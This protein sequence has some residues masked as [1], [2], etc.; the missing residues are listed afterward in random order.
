MI[1][2]LRQNGNQRMNLCDFGLAPSLKKEKR[3]YTEGRNSFMGKR[4]DTANMPKP[5]CYDNTGK[6]RLGSCAHAGVMSTHNCTS[7]A[8]AKYQGSIVENVAGGVPTFA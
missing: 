3:P 6:Y 4:I 8:G 1:F 7:E 2:L 5:G